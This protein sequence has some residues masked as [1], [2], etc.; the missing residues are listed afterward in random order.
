MWIERPL[1]PLFVQYA[2]D[3]AR[4]LLELWRRMSL[5]VDSGLRVDL[6]LAQSLSQIQASMADVIMC[7][8][9]T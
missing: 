2:A 4:L 9:F 5:S 8:I 6:S 1:E 3:D 7:Q